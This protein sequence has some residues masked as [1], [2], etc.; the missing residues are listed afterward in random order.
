[1]AD[2]LTREQLRAKLEELLRRK[3]T[4]EADKKHSNA[5]Y[6]DELK[7]IKDEMKSVLE[8]IDNIGK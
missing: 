8:E 6:N 7:D 1:M 5:T 2:K 4:V 3:Q